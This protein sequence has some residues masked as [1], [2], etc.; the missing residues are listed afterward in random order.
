MGSRGMLLSH[1]TI[2]FD[3]NM[4]ISVA[5]V[6]VRLLHLPVIFWDKVTLKAIGDKLGLFINQAEIKLGMYTCARIC[7]EVDLEKRL[8]KAIQLNM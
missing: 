3:L 5:P 1:W 7:V 2:D 8:P 4:D 6:W